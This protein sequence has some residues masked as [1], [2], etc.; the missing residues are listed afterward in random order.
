MPSPAAV[1]AFAFHEVTRDPSDS[2]FQRPAALPY[3]LTPE[4]FGRC[5]D[6]IT[7]ARHAPTLVTDR[8]LG[9]GG[10]RIFLTFDDGGRSALRAGDELVRRGWRGHF[11]VV[12]GRIG[13]RTFLAREEIRRLAD[14]GHLI[15]SHSHSHPDIFRELT[16]ARMA[17]EWR[18]SIDV[19]S[20]LLGAPCDVGSVPGGDISPRVLA[21]AGPA[22]LR[23]LFTSEPEV[24]PRM[25]E[26]CWVVGR[27][28][29]KAGMRPE[30]IAALAEFRGWTAALAERRL[31]VLA[32][33]SIPLLYRLSVRHRT[34]EPGDAE[35][36]GGIERGRP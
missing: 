13:G 32:R 33:R 5:L 3:K 24:R 31:R 34:R 11:F 1:A 36:A 28:N 10:K 20:Q 22:G 17:E 8:P 14:D 2:G 21:S 35:A 23:H 16:P 25:V 15:G 9:G 26:G 12:T 18:V 6:G 19:L 27:F 30:R 29:V 7:R 4:A